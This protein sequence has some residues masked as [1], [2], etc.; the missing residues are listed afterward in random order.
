MGKIYIMSDIHGLYDR[1]E[2]MLEKIGL[3]DGDR[4]Y[5]LG[6]VID[7]GPDSFK[8]LQDIMDR[9]NV[10]LFLGNHEHMML[11]YLDGLD[12]KSWFF[13]ANGGKE[14]Y[15]KLMKLDSGQREQIVSYI[16][17][18]TAVIRNLEINGHSYI[19]SHTG[20]MTDGRDRFT[21][22][23]AGKLME[24]QDFVWN[25]FPYSLEMLSYY[26]RIEKPVVLISGHII[27][28]RLS[29]KDEVYIHDFENGYVWYNIDCGC[30]MGDGLGRLSCLRIDEDGEIGEI[31]YVE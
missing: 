24:I 16:R 12:R 31:F 19:L 29:G 30:A 11:T 6:D 21:R 28:R 25:M 9:E 7:R 20:V 10:E 18:E 1:Y 23:Y 14:T 4:L 27:S 22:D 15:Q 17:N 3:Q 2:A 8:I 5:V 13:A 26:G